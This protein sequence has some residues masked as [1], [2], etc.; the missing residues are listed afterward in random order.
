MAV[1]TDRKDE[2][3]PQLAPNDTL[4]FIESHRPR[5]KAGDYRLR[6]TH[7]VEGTGIVQEPFT[8]ANQD[9]AVA[10]PRF[11]LKPD[12]IQGVF[13]P[14]GA[15][16]L[17]SPVLPHIILKR[18]TL[19]WE[20]T[21]YRPD[22]NDAPLI[23]D[24]KQPPWLALLVFTQGEI[25]SRAVKNIP[26]EDARAPSGG[27]TRFPGLPD[28]VSDPAGTSCTVIEVAWQVLQHLVPSPSDLADLTHV[29]QV[30]SELVDDED[31]E[32]AVVIAG[33]LP[34]EE[35]HVTAHLVSL[36]G[37]YPLAN[38]DTANPE[39]EFFYRNRGGG[40]RRPGNTDRIRLISL[41]SWSFFCQEAPFD[42]FDNLFERLNNN[43]ATP[44]LLRLPP[45]NSSI[46]AQKAVEN[47]FVPLRHKFRY[48]DRSVSWYH[49]PFIPGA[50]PIAQDIADQLWANPIRSSDELLIYN[51]SQGLFDVSYA[52]AW[53]LGRRLV[54]ENQRVATR[55]YDWKRRHT[56]FFLC[57]KSHDECQ[58]LPIDSDPGVEPPLDPEVEE[59]FKTQLILLESIPFNYLVPDER[60][61]PPESI[62]FFNL[63]PL[64]LMMLCD[65]AFSLDRVTVADAEKDALRRVHLPGAGPMSGFLMR[66]KLVS[67]WP[68]MA[69]DAY[70]SI[71][72]STDFPL[73]LMDERVLPVRKDFLSPTVLM[74]LYAGDVQAA[75]FY[76]CPETIHF[77]VQLDTI[78]ATRE[79]FI[80]KLQE[81]DDVAPSDE[82]DPV[83]FRIPTRFRVIDI[84]RLKTEMA[85]LLGRPTE[86]L[87]PEEFAW[88]M[89]DG[90]PFVRLKRETPV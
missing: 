25:A 41:Y 5:L 43:H 56:N 23:D 15:T 84:N 27:G 57:E 36:E 21:A 30:S 29:R 45:V 33:R 81:M 73:D 66:S 64:W 68:D 4:R 14:A 53:E 65:G 7:E 34:K 16:G 9:F 20:R 62:R 10:G 32:Q 49:G 82:I 50:P 42:N 72:A 74:M 59:W 60:M 6:V 63:D 78:D 40:N 13:P 24:S 87:S 75:D 26:I 55:L 61:L 47:G 88:Q 79:K 18:S 70:R 71:P 39:F 54:L 89:I 28:Q 67:G 58:H 37:F 46:D 8:S 51:E 22:N 90:A 77:G 69:I 2:L 12:D 52:A 19:P 44:A 17:F 11:G 85:E 1:R 86:P 31:G 80:K 83:P 35:T 76:L 3:G 38:N 48:G